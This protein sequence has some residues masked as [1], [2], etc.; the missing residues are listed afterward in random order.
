MRMHLQ[1][2]RLVPK[3][4]V[5]QAECIGSLLCDLDC[6]AQRRPCL[7]NLCLES[8][9]LLLEGFSFKCEVCG[10][11]GARERKSAAVDTASKETYKYIFSP[12][13]MSEKN[14]SSRC[15]FRVRCS[16]CTALGARTAKAVEDEATSGFW[17]WRWRR[18]RTLFSA[19]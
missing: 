16:A 3:V 10:P 12:Y 14:R 19:S 2:A 4:I 9:V 11:R 5:E 17:L 8:T 15:R 7:H 18:P 1:S 13:R 6:A